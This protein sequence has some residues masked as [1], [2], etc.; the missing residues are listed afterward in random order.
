[1]ETSEA[2]D[3]ILVDGEELS[4]ED[5]RNLKETSTNTLRDYHK[6]TEALAREREQVRAEEEK[7]RAKEQE[8]L[9]AR[10]ALMSDVLFYKTNPVE[11]WDG[12]VAEIDKV[13][14]VAPAVATPPAI[15]PEQLKRIESLD[16]EV[17]ELRKER[18]L[19]K[20]SAARELVDELASSVYKSADVEHCKDRL[21]VLLDTRGSIPTKD[22]IKELVKASHD[23]E[24]KKRAVVIKNASDEL[25]EKLGASGGSVTI[26][27]LKGGSE[28]KDTKAPLPALSDTDAITKLGKDFFASR[29]ASRGGK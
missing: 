6:K 18:V 25:R 17:S 26:P 3:K 21:Y 23:R 7:I 19:E 22:E 24:E 15:A 1:M 27:S 4:L 13:M 5:I 20:V 11:N 28:A 29:R 12:H 10:E 2:G 14:G 16:K 9:K 8:V